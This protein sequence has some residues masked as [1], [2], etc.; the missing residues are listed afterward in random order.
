M[1]A[2]ASILTLAGCFADAGDGPSAS[3]AP[4]ASPTPT[5][6]G[7][8]VPRLVPEGTASDNLPLFSA[9]TDAVWAGPDNASGR[10]YVDALVAA[11]FDRSAMQVTADR[12]TVGNAAESLQYSV[13]WG[14]ECLI[15]Q[16]GPATGS[17][18]T[19]VADGLAD[20]SCLL[21]STRV[22]DW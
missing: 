5:S 14:E 18:V 9:V 19:L 12:S 8:A 22:I 2:G 10:A 13:R 20:G 11:G 1:L 17:P 4:S 6:T 15:G 21:G 16:V 7:D 3:S